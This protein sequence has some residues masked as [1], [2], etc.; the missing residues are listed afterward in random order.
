MVTAAAEPFLWGVATSAFQIEGSPDADW[1]AWDA[2]ARIQPLMTGHYERFREDV[3]LLRTLGVNA[4]RFSVEWSRIQP[5]ERVW[6]ETAIDHYRQLVG[7][8]LASGIHPVLTL[9]HNT[10]PRWFHESTPWHGGQAAERFAAFV[11]RVVDAIPEVTTWI[12]FN[13][14]MI[15]LLGGYLDGC[16]PPGKCDYAAAA[17]AFRG[18]L[19]A[20]ARAYAIIHGRI[21]EARVGIAHNMAVFAPLRRWHPLDRLLAR[22]GRRGFNLAILE[23][24]RTGRTR[25]ALPFARPVPIAAPVKGMLDFL[26][27]NYYQRLHLKFR[28][29]RRR[30]RC[31][32]VI[33]RDGGGTG[34]TD[35]GW[36]EHPDGLAAVL[37]EA[38]AVGVPLLLTENGIATTDDARKISFIRRHVAALD[39]SRRDGIDIQGYFYWSLTDTYEWL[40]GLDKRF[41]L[42]R[43][44][45]RTLERIPTAAAV[46]YA[47][48]VRGRRAAF[49]S[50]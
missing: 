34:L 40:H 29:Q 6:D 33:H 17:C 8:L 11:R 14:P 26:G 39:A 31:L 43:M 9:H 49:T 41:G 3:A 15:M 7:E 45:W 44:D 32:E 5:G 37:R 1:A 2:G 10:H 28:L 48:L 13:E 50:T 21:P 25:L 24:F 18:V 36:E 19:D 42:Y 22:L 27:V 35:M 12:T 4:Y 16:L 30:S 23:V 47:A 46:Y 38:A 20:H